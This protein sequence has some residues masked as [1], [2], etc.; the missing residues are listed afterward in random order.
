MPWQMQPGLFR[1]DY[2]ANMNDSYWLSSPGQPLEG[3]PGIMGGERQALS[4]RGRLGHRIAQDLLAQAPLDTQALSR[5]LRQDVLDARVYSAELFKPAVLTQV[6]RARTVEVAADPATGQTFTPPQ[7]V[8]IAPACA[9]LKQWDNTGNAQDRGAHLWEAFWARVEQIEP[10]ALFRVPF[11]PQ[12]P[13]DTPTDFNA[14]DPHVAEALGAAVLATSGQGL[15]PDA[16]RGSYLNVDSGRA[17]VPLYG[18][19]EDAGYFTV[20]CDKTGGY[21]IDGA[22]FGNSYLQVVSFGDEGVEA[23]ILLAHGQSETALEGGRDNDAL[24][25]YAEKRWLHFPFR[26]QEMARD[27]Q[28]ERVVLRP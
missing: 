25:R 28:F 14:D 15:A 27:P 21:R 12:H 23:Y 24:R 7:G 9:A 11:S 26:E 16:A 20:L 1:E 13:L 3:Y 2:V 5:R 22:S 4:L 19:C 6:C 10:A 17:R 8:D 18:G